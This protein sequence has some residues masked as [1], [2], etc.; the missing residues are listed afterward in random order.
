LSSS[1]GNF[2]PYVSAERPDGLPP[3]ER[4]EVF[5][6]T[7]EPGY[8]GVE[9]LGIAIRLLSVCYAQKFFGVPEFIP[10]AGQLEYSNRALAEVTFLQLDSRCCRRKFF[11]VDGV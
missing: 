4:N 7:K 5:G 8:L 2:F 3:G 1:V 11:G 9:L 6:E 10:Q